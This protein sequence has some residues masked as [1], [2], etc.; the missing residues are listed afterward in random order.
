MR[1][2]AALLLAT[3]L[4]LEACVV[5]PIPQRVVHYPT[6]VGRLVHA[7]T[8]EAAAGVLVSIGEPGACP[9][10]RSN[11]RGEFELRATGSRFPYTS[12]WWRGDDPPAEIAVIWATLGSGAGAVR[13]RVGQILFYPP[14][15]ADPGERNDVPAELGVIR[16]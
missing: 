12:V 11:E 4:G 7:E 1:A 14:S 5:L 2:R 15:F 6:L 8:G 3:T 9:C 16:F 10:A 13:R